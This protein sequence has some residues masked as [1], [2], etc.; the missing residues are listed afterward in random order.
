MSESLKIDTKRQI[1]IENIN[2]LSLDL[3]KDIYR[4]IAKE[5]KGKDYS[6]GIR[7]NFKKISENLVSQIYEIVK[8]NI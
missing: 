2:N 3:K 5:D 7:L 1:I 4:L 6:D 8:E